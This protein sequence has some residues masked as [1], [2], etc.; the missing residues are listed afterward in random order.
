MPSGDAPCMSGNSK[1]LHEGPLQREALWQAGSPRDLAGSP[2]ASR[3]TSLLLIAE[4]YEIAIF[5]KKKNRGP[6]NG[7]LAAVLYSSNQQFCWPISLSP[8]KTNLNPF[9]FTIPIFSPPPLLSPLSCLLSFE[10]KL[11]IDLCE[12][13]RCAPSQTFSNLALGTGRAQQNLSAGAPMS[14]QCSIFSPPS[15]SHTHLDHSTEL[16]GSRPKICSQLRSSLS[17][18]CV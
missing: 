2:P 4:P 9:G 14:A 7:W 1:S 10:S 8:R 13:S 12:W 17:L 16:P 15:Q 5:L 11:G 3:E 6:T 18:A